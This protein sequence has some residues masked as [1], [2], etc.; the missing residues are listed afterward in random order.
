MFSLPVPVIT[1]F[2]IY[3]VSTEI[4][5]VI[6]FCRS[7]AV[8]SYNYELPSITKFLIVKLSLISPSNLNKTMLWMFEPVLMVKSWIARVVIVADG[9]K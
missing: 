7:K 9:L 5:L 4:K 8:T 6:F 3:T 2:L 1:L